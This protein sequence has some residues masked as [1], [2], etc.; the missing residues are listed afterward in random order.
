MNNLI[1][2]N[3]ILLFNLDHTLRQSPLF[4]KYLSIH[5]SL[6]RPPG[7]EYFLPRNMI[8]DLN[9]PWK[10]EPTAYPVPAM[11]ATPVSFEEAADDFGLTIC[12]E[13]DQGRQVYLMWSGGIDSTAVAVSVLK[14]ITPVQYPNFHLVLSDFSRHENPIFYHKFLKQFDQIDI[15]IFDPANIDMKNSIILDG[16]G[17][18]QIF[19]SSAANRIFGQYPE[20]IMLPWRK[21]L[22]FLRNCWHNPEVP[23]FWDHVLDLMQQ[24]IDHGPVPIETC[25]DFFWWLNF[26]FK[27]DSAPFRH[28]LRLSSNV[29][30]SD[31]KYFAQ[32]V[33]RR[34]YTSEKIQQW[35]M[36]AGASNKINTAKKTVKWAGR[37]YIYEFDKNEYYFREKRKEF[38]KEAASTTGTRYFAIDKNYQRYSFWDRETRQ[39]IG[40]VFNKRITS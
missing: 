38:S 12:R 22:D 4:S 13:L 36:S 3:H 29:G 1:F 7:T 30:D 5:Q 17:G 39:N 28:T 37:E 35:S 2:L 31:F 23:I 32:T 9:G 14:Y 16:E 18:D 40:N 26:N 20:K 25:F 34:L 24:T 19:G 15:S 27:L 10:L 8:I 11:P 33:M 21:N 6:P